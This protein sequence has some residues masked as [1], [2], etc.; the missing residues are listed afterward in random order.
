MGSQKLLLTG[1]ST[2]TVYRIKRGEHT[3]SNIHLCNNK[4]LQMLM[5]IMWISELFKS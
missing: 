4:E 1:W 5:R 3:L 2:F